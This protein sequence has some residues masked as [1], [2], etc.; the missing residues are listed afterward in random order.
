MEEYAENEEETTK[1]IQSRAL[2]EE[3]L[4][5]RIETE[6]PTEEGKKRKRDAEE[7]KTEHR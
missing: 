3:R 6:Q 2:Q 4:E 7:T 5:A 1:E